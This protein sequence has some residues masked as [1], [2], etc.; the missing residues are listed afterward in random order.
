MREEI[1]SAEDEARFV[2]SF[3][4]ES[5]KGRQEF[6]PIWEE[7][8]QNYIVQPYGLGGYTQ[9]VE[10][11]YLTGRREYRNDGR[12][13]LKDT[14]SHQVVETLLSETWRG[15]FSNPDYIKARRVGIEDAFKAT[16][17]ARLVEHALRLPGHPRSFYVWLKDG[18]MLGTGLLECFWH[19]DERPQV[20]T[21]VGFDAGYEFV[22][23][24]VITMPFY[25]DIR[26]R[27]VDI[28]D[29]FPDFGADRLGDMIGTAKRF[30]VTAKKADDMVEAGQWPRDAVDKAKMNAAA[31]DSRTQ[32][33]RA[34]REGYDR[35]QAKRHEAF[36]SM[37]AY[38]YIGEVPHRPKDGERFRRIEI[39]SGELVKSEPWPYGQPYYDFTVNPIQ[40]RFYGLSPLEVNRF[41]QD[42]A[43]QILRNICD[44]LNKATHPPFIVERY[45]D[46]DQAKLKAFKPD[47]VV[48]AN[49]VTAVQQLQYKPPVSEATQLYFSLKDSQR[50]AGGA[51]GSVQ[52]LGLGINRASASEAVATFQQAKGRPEMIAELIEQ[53]YLPPIGRAV[54]GLYKRFLRD[55]QDLVA[56][57][58]EQPEPVALADIHADWD[59]A[60]VGS[61]L[62]QTDE[63]QARSIER[64]VRAWIQTPA[65]A[66]IPWSELFKRHVRALH[67]DEIEAF[68]SDPQLV[69]KNLI[70]QRL[71][72]PSKALGNGNGE[73]P[74]EPDAE[75]LMEAQTAGE[76]A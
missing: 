21:E 26:I 3:I 28:M 46:V 71:S 55:T 40:G 2:M 42:F 53:E 56:R 58:G 41:H 67:L 19:Y 11:P 43:D 61:R 52:G 62:A 6:E 22:E 50:Q 74:R 33:D 24:T 57:I 48:T 73:I 8:I 65:A 34:W 39:L 38:V 70:L 36:K 27:P 4:D 15:L 5:S 76:A 49:T 69:Q 32:R 64:L 68:V 30:T 59:V 75:G 25:D 13:V 35:P 31:Q 47:V 10:Y 37:T 51:L 72:A 60:F 17:V 54:L 9:R 20:V 63:D 45:A 1:A 16:T 18:F 7:A 23:E 44:G 29:F 14:E 66:E 12:A